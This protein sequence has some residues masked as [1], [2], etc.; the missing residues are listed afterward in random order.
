MVERGS[1]GERPR[2]IIPGPERGIEYLMMGI[3]LR[4]GIDLGRYEALAGSP[5]NTNKI[6]ALGD[7]GMISLSGGSLIATAKGRL[8]LNAIIREL[9]A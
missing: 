5:L 6:N 7:L 1:A 9:V 8:L 3:R 2:D 4:E